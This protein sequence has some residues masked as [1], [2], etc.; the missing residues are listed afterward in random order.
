MKNGSFAGFNKCLS[1]YLKHTC[2]RNASWAFKHL[3][4]MSNPAFRPF[5]FHPYAKLLVRLR[6]TSIQLLT[7]VSLP[8]VYPL[9]LL[10]LLSFHSDSYY[11]LKTPFRLLNPRVPLEW[12]LKDF[13]YLFLER[14]E[15]REKRGREA[16]DLFL[17]FLP[18]LTNLVPSQYL[19]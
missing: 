10:N 19:L 4:K 6:P 16:I 1:R 14:G 2:R 12:F 9:F 7:S 15:G 11:S 3:A 18:S 5:L 8:F 13:I 17:V